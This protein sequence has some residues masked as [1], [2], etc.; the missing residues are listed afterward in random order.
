M[1]NNTAK[2]RSLVEEN[3]RT[4]IPRMA[5]PTIVAQMITT[6]Y[7]LV[8]TYF[9]STLGTAA[10]AAVGVNSSLERL[11]TIIGS[12]IG[13]GACSYI[14]RLLGGKK[15]K[16][17]DR[18]LSTAFLTG[19]GLGVLL[20]AAGRLLMEPM[21]YWL[22]A[23]PDCADYAMQY[24]NYVLYAAPFM[25]GSFILN[26]CLRSEGSAT[27]AMIGI[28][29]GGILNCILD[30]I[31]IYHL[32]LGV[33]GAAMATAISKAISFFILLWPYLRRRTSVSIALRLFRL[34]SRDVK[35][36]LAI[37]S[38]SFFRSTLT[39]AAAIAVNRVAGRYSTSALAGLSVATRVM[40]FPFALVLGFGQGYQP[41]VSYNW[42][43]AQWKRVRESFE[44]SIA[45]ALIGAAVVGAALAVFAGPAVNLFNKQADAEVLRLGMLSIR[46]Q[47]LALPVHALGVVVGMFYAGTGNARAALVVNTAR[48]GY[49]FFPM[50]LILPLFMGINGVAS[51]QAAADVLSGLVTGPLALKAR[52]IVLAKDA[53]GKTE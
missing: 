53:A 3:I 31:F 28:G 12:L 11:I 7:N 49:C 1:K 25:I 14:A 51:A 38:S 15:D 30:P 43:A 13:S 4:L 52:R 20:M 17:A 27:F 29:F 21:V 42:G 10:T 23:T 2:T 37:G 18:V 32:G 19:L 50:L 48:Q 47:A 34:V 9:V 41:V 36:V 40:A 22:G 44:F 16:D 39:V 6:I 46:L 5:V 8:D 33:A 45:T 26:M 24:A 35:E